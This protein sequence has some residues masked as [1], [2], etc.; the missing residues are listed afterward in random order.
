MPTKVVEG[1]AFALVPTLPICV[2]EGMRN[3]SQMDMAGQSSNDPIAGT[4]HSIRNISGAAVCVSSPQHGAEE[5]CKTRGTSD[6][7]GM[8]RSIMGRYAH[9]A[10]FGNDPFVG[11]A[12][13]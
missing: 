9:A 2:V 3:V 12:S 5:F 8:G 7:P 6:I 13:H 1:D 4:G 11:A 10:L